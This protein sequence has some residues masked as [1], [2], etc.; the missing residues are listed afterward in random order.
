LKV[1]FGEVTAAGFDYGNFEF[2]VLL[3]NSQTMAILG[4]AAPVTL[5]GTSDEREFG[6][7]FTSMT[8]GALM[9]VNF[10]NAGYPGT[11]LLGSSAFGNGSNNPQLNCDNSPCEGQ[12]T[13][14]YTP[15]AGTYQLLFGSFGD[16]RNFP[17]AV[18]VESVSVPE[19]GSSLGYA[20]TGFLVV[21]LLRRR[22]PL[23]KQS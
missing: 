2:A 13:S 18:T 7:V 6:T 1:N 3:Q 4:L 16:G 23:L 5:V 9:T 11:F 15:G 14:T 21:L 20:A 22:I 12:F 8:P 10:Y 17:A 19:G